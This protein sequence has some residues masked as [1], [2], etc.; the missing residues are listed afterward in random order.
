MNLIH[1][2]TSGPDE[3]RAWT[4]KEGTLAPGA[5]GTIHTDFEKNFICAEV[6]KFKDFF[7]DLDVDFLF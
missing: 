6:H 1:F 7:A 3:V 2:F 4:I 5:A